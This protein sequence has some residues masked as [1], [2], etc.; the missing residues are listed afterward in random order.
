MAILKKIA[1]IQEELKVEK[2]GYDE[3]QDYW[4]YKAEDVAAAVRAKMVQHGVIHRTV[5][6]ELNEDNF[7]DQN[8]RNRPRVTIRGQVVF[9]DP[10]DGS[11]FV[12]EAVATGSDTG[13]DKGTR[14]A[15]VQLFKIAVIDLFVIAGEMARADSDGDRETEPVNVSPQVQVDEPR[16]V[17]ELSAEIG[18]L[19]KSGVTD[20][21]VVKAIGTRVSKQLLGDKWTEKFNIRSDARILDIVVADI[22]KGL[23]D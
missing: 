1:T 4:Y 22:K 6:Q 18:S 19:I 15:A 2:T 16:T 17:S 14:K 11:E 9:I 12:T 5:I 8:G 21:G 7:Y 10:D 20:A 23:V 3:R 13:G